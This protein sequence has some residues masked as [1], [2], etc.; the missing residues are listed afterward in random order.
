MGLPTMAMRRG[1]PTSSKDCGGGL[2]QRGE[3][4][5]EHVARAAA[6]ERGDAERLAQAEVPQAVG[7]GLGALVVDLVGGEDDGLARRPQDAYDG[8]V[9][10]GDADH[11]V[12]HE[13]HG[14][15]QRHRH[16][17]LGADGLGHAARVGVP[18]AGVDHGEGAAVP[19]GVVVDAVA[20]DAG[21]VLDDG[22][23]AADDPVDQGGLAHV[24]AAHDGQ[25]GGRAGRL[26]WTRLDAEGVVLTHDFYSSVEG[27]TS[28][29]SGSSSD[30]PARRGSGK[31]RRVCARALSSSD[32]MCPRSNTEV[33]RHVFPGAGPRLL[34]RLPRPAE[35]DVDVAAAGRQRLRAV[36]RPRV[37]R[38]VTGTTGAPVTSAR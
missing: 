16:L 7:L 20:G 5:V 24:G 38:R 23:A 17:G 37:P 19:V 10:V 35:D 29:V 31:D 25:D 36:A 28:P 13:E 26:V 9:G 1:P 30:C 3:D 15:G 4:G 12:D 34:C 21:T 11:R 18:A 14:V 6:V 2:G 32:S 33:A 8:L 27:S 22:L